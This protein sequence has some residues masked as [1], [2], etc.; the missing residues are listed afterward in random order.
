MRHR[1]GKTEGFSSL[2]VATDALVKRGFLVGHDGDL[3]DGGDRTL[4]WASSSDADND[5]GARAVGEI[6]LPLEGAS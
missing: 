2:R 6:R 4:F 1:D 3:T 5:D